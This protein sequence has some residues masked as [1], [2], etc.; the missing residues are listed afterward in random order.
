MYVIQIHLPRWRSIYTE[1]PK[2]GQRAVVKDKHNRMALAL[3]TVD[4][5]VILAAFGSHAPNPEVEHWILADEI[6]Q[7]LT[8]K[9]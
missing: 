1:V 2:L 6:T 9:G 7:M 4:G 3:W 8:L 5:F